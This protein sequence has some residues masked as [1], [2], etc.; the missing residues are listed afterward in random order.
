MIQAESKELS[1]DKFR[2]THTLE[3][4]GMSEENNRY[5][6]L[7]VTS[8]ELFREMTYIFSLSGPGVIC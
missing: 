1:V 3:Q 6:Y 2:S 4:W 8:R 5:I 7:W